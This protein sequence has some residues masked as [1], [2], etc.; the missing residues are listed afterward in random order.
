METPGVRW[1]LKARKKE[2][3]ERMVGACSS[4]QAAR[5]A[6]EQALGEVGS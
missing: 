2:S 3:D 1:G 4:D 5:N 6:V